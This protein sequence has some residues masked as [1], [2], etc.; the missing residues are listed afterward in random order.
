MQADAFHRGDMDVLATATDLCA[1]AVWALA[2]RGF[3]VRDPDQGVPLFVQGIDDHDVAETLT[4]RIV[5]A[6]LTPA[7]RRAVEDPRALPRLA[8]AEARDHLLAHGTRAGRVLSLLEPEERDAVPAGVDDLDAVLAG[9]AAPSTAALQPD[10]NQR[11]RLNR[12][13]ALCQ[14]AETDLDERS[15][16]LVRLRFPEGRTRAEIAA[17]FTCGEAAVTAHEGR[18]R[19]QLRR[20]LKTEGLACGDAM[21]DAV[22]GDAPHALTPPAV[23]RER[24]RRDVLRRTFQDE[25]AP[26]GQRLAWAMGMAAIAF[27]AW[28][29]MFF[30]VLPYYDDDRYPTPN[31]AVRC[32]GPCAPGAEAR[33]SILAPQD[34]RRVALAVVRPDLRATAVL[35]ADDGRSIRLPFG[36]REAAVPIPYPVT[37]PADLGPEDRA[38]AVFSWDRLDEREIREAASGAVVSAGVLT[39]SVALK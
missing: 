15:R 2:R 11:S 33:F 38:V 29:L 31:V 35:T 37:L 22:L 34:A 32:T 9:Q 6:L 36:A 26:F 3:L 24:I 28:A 18:L 8:L 25:P 27:T 5:A 39:A 21:L 12:A 17:H 20:H 4:I 14:S 7:R 23:T 10:A 13:I 30:G 1:P 19:R 16:T